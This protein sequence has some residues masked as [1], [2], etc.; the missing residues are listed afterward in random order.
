MANNADFRVSIT[1]V[2]RATATIRSVNNSIGKLT[3][4]ISNAHRTMAAMGKEFQLNPAVKGL[5]KMKGAAEGVASMLSKVSGVSLGLTGIGVVAG[6]AELANQWGRLGFE[7]KNTSAS[8][9]ISTSDLMSMRGAARLAGLS[10]DDMTGALGSLSKTLFDT[11]VGNN[12]RMV[13]VMNDLKIGYHEAADGGFDLIA[14]MKD[15]SRAM[16]AQK[17]VGAKHAIADNMGLSALYNFL[18]KGPDAIDK[19]A[20]ANKK[21]AGIPSNGAI[22][23]AEKYAESLNRLSV[24]A[25]GVKNSLGDKLIPAVQ[26]LIDHLTAFLSNNQT[27]IADAASGTASTIVK[28]KMFLPPPLRAGID[29]WDSLTSG[30][31]NRSVS[32][33]IAPV[34]SAPGMRYND[35]ALNAYANL[36]EERNGLPKN[37]LN[38]IKNFG[39]RSNPGAVSSKGARGVMQFMPET[40]KQYGKG[41]PS[42]S[43]AS[44]DA[45]GAYFKDLMKRYDGN[46]DA[47]ITEYN[48][49]TRQARAVQGGGSPWAAE[50]VNYLSRVKSGMSSMAAGG[51][52][53]APQNVSITLSG[54]PAGVTATAKS[55]G[56][57]VPVR[58]SRAMP[59]LDPI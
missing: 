34:G 56:A 16:A 14:V 23:Q 59:T 6:I 18:D 51:A 54:L 13:G 28:N 53:S 57:D 24:A 9:G 40:W 27:G 38:G 7:V 11:K 35:P 41:D 30:G 22:D 10:A 55:S 50:T 19:W 48:G 5:V 36:V 12:P 17:S 45:G 43:Y 44:I 39:E 29:L 2:D 8:L 25:D 52:A 37:I 3:R 26:P 1:A 20:A 21:L 31:G 42:N 33:K 58:I 4:P 47:A 49:G 32:G 46:V 15:V